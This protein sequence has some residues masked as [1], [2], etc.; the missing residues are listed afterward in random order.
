M[1][2]ARPQ[3]LG[4]FLTLFP[5]TFSQIRQLYKKIDKCL[6]RTSAAPFLPLFFPFSL[7][8]LICSTIAFFFP[9][10]DLSTQ[11]K[12]CNLAP[13][14]SIL[15]LFLPFSLSSLFKSLVRAAAPPRLCLRPFSHPLFLLFCRQPRERGTPIFQ[16]FSPSLSL[17][18]P[19]TLSY[20]LLTY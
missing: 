18:L 2:T 12:K 17:P 20:C 7:M 16:T 8:P 4:G 11:R 14:K 3:G 1:I 5:V 13:F 15:R 9:S 19:I 6:I 10:I